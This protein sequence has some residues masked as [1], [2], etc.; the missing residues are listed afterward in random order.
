MALSVLLLSYIAFNALLSLVLMWLAR[1]EF[2]TR[3]RWSPGTAL[4]SGVVMH[5]QALAT[6]ALAFTDA[7]SAYAPT[8][9]SLIAGAILF[10]AGAVVIT[11]GR[12][13]YGSQKRVYGLLEDKLI[14]NG[15]Y[16]LTRNPQYVG[17]FGMFAGAA[18]AGGS[19]L[20]IAS[21]LLFAMFVHVFITRV[22]EPHMR[23]AF[24]EPYRAYCAGVRRY[25]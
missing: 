2:R 19:R 3:G 17:Y 6:F 4:F 13:A 1:R 18:L 20:A 16:R 23:A 22:E 15:I 12:R 5:G 8:E 21:T 9:A 10:A 14:A 11:L 24:G 7:G 25:L